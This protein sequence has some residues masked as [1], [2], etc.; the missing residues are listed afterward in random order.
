MRNLYSPWGELAALPHITIEWARMAGRLGEY[1]H[2]RQV[3]RLDPTML[4]RQ[5]RCVLAHEL[6][7]ALAGDE[8][9]VDGIDHRRR[10]L[11]T[12]RATARLLI[13][14]HDLGDAMVLQGHHLGAVASELD[15]SIDALRHRLE[16]LHPAERH[17][18]T[19]R[20]DSENVSA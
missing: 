3:I 11:R 1:I 5:R 19:R 9:L 12:D 17:A 20:L 18:L 4:R 2:D 6:R 14:I 15:V 10:E 16:S 13:D 7:H 8:P